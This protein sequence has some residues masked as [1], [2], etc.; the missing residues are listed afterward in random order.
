VLLAAAPGE[1]TTYWSERLRG[2][3]RDELG[4]D[5]ALVVGY[6]QDHE[7]YLLLPEDWLSGDATEVQINLWGPLQGEYLLERELDVAALLEAG[8]VDPDPGPLDPAPDVWPLEPVVPI[9]T[10]RAGDALEQPAPEVERLHSA[11]FEWVGG[12][13]AVDQPRVTLQRK[14]GGSYRNVQLPSG[15][16]LDDRTHRIVLAYRPDPIDAAPDAIERHRYR[17]WFQVVEDLPSVSHAAGFRT[18]TYRFRVKGRAR[19]GNRDTSYEVVSKPF[20]VLP[21]DDLGLAELE[22][23]G[24]VVRGRVVLPPATGY[25]LESL[26]TPAGESIPVAEAVVR[27]LPSGGGAGT[28]AEGRFELTVPPS[29]TELVVEDSFGNRAGVAVPA[30]SSAGRR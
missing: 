14:S 21:T 27:A 18:G 19:K 4:F 8:P 13:P 15:R 17:A 23:E 30:A 5:E 28:D 11:S 3:A 16:P 25:R 1:P 2:R 9:A 10:P 7:G 22:R 29:T 24:D 12:D 6:A 26:A 20:R